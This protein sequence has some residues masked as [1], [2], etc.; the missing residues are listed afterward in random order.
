MNNLRER[1]PAPT[2]VKGSSE[3]QV[4]FIYPTYRA[5]QT[6]THV[7]KPPLKGSHQ[8][9]AHVSSTVGGSVSTLCF[10]DTKT[11]NQPSP[12]RRRS[13]GIR[14]RVRLLQGKLQEPP[15]TSCKHQ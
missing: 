14:D 8:E 9:I 6:E 10:E 7:D 1:N 12:S 3:D 5:A 2:R 11:S 13:G 4:G 15:Q